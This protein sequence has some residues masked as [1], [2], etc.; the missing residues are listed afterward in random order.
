MQE[1]ADTNF[2]RVTQR[3]F[4]RKH[5]IVNN[6]IGEIQQREETIAKEIENGLK[7]RGKEL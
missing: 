5:D 4:L 3:T 7:I 1:E 2:L 6:L